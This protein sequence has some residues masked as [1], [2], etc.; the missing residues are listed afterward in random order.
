LREK[1]ESVVKAEETS[2]ALC[3][4]RKRRRIADHVGMEGESSPHRKR[5]ME[6]LKREGGVPDIEPSRKRVFF[7][8]QDP[9]RIGEKVAH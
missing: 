6:I 9:P 7:L 8:E 1:G 5:G 2:A 3:A 4:R